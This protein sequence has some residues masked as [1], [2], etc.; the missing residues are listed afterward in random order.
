MAY[1][2]SIFSQQLRI[3][4]PFLPIFSRFK[5]KYCI[6]MGNMVECYVGSDVIHKKTA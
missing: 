6:K 1:V 2:I 3:F 5:S 4:W